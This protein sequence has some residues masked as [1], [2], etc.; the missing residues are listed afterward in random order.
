MEVILIEHWCGRCLTAP[1]SVIRN[2]EMLFLSHNERGIL[3]Q[4]HF[5]VVYLFKSATDLNKSALERLPLVCQCL[6]FPFW[7]FSLHLVCALETNMEEVEMLCDSAMWPICRLCAF[8]FPRPSR[9]YLQ[10]LTA[11]T[12][13]QP[14]AEEALAS[15]QAA[16]RK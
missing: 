16:R 1:S 4:M 9:N 10:A 3:L 7:H 15:S 8:F 12:R 5:S 6:F 13:G 11:L 2:G 14:Q